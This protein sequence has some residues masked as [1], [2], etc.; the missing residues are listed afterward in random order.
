MTDSLVNMIAHINENSK[1]EEMYQVIQ[2]SSKIL[3]KTRTSKQVSTLLIGFFLKINFGLINC[4]CKD[5]LKFINIK[6]RLNLL[7]I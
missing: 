2:L 4:N 5:I 6:R 7:F 3:K 1:N